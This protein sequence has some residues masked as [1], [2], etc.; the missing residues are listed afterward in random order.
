MVDEESESPARIAG[1]VF[2]Y[3]GIVGEGG[4]VGGG[5]EF[6]LLQGGNLDL[7]VAQEVLQL[8]SG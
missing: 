8:H 1:A 7:V 3:E 6:G 4:G 2:P 5:V